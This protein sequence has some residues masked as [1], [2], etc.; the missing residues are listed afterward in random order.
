MNL[1]REPN[2]LVRLLIAGAF[3]LLTTS[4]FAG[5]IDISFVS[6]ETREIHNGSLVADLDRVF[7]GAT[8]SASLQYNSDGA[9]SGGNFYQ[10]TDNWSGDIAGQ[11]FSD[12]VGGGFANNGGT[13]DGLLL[14]FG[15]AF[16]PHVGFDINVGGVDFSLAFGVLG[17]VGDDILPATG[18]PTSLPTAGVD[19]VIAQLEFRD[20]DSNA[21]RIEGF[22]QSGNLTTSPVTE[23]STL[24]LLGLGL[25][26]IGFRR[27][28]YKHSAIS[29]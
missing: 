21:Y 15:N 25:A 9:L 1:R 7:G 22:V 5:L 18:L 11:L 23:P 12:T 19:F 20:I 26:G 3:G 14:T 10:A 17:W 29:S 24:I 28:N 6:D 4:S 2:M 27:R 13:T 16:G 8:I